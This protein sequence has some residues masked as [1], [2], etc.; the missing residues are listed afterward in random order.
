LDK[1]E[2]KRM[3]VNILVDSGAYMMAI[4]ENIQQQLD[5]P[6]IDTRKV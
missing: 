2:V 4:N 6:F 3:V 1:E 5:L